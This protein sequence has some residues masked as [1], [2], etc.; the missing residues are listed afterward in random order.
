MIVIDVGCAVRGANSIEPL[1]EEFHPSILYG[2]D[3]AVTRSSEILEGCRIVLSDQAAWVFDGEVGFVPDGSG[4]HVAVG[5]GSP[6]GCF[7]LARFVSELA[8][9]GEKIVLKID[10]EGAE[11]DLLD[12]LIGTGA[13]RLLG[14]AWVE[15]HLPDRGRRRIE[16]QISCV[17]IGWHR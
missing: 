12:H 7:D 11:Y 15:W 16:E 14:L 4:S 9:E 13:D 8:I 10:A 2:F 5:E 1:I 17:V 6:V 3:P